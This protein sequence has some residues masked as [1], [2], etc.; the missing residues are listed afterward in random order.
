MMAVVYVVVESC[1]CDE[2]QTVYVSGEGLFVWYAHYVVLS[3]PVDNIQYTGSTALGHP[4]NFQTG[5]V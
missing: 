2:R 3:I 5:P 4:E 1:L